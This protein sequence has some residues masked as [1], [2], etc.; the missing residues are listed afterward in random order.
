M[1]DCFSRRKILVPC[2]YKAADRER[3]TC[4]AKAWRK[5]AYGKSCNS[6][7]GGQNCG[8]HFLGRQDLCRCGSKLFFKELQI[9]FHLSNKSFFHFQT[10]TRPC[11]IFG[12][13]FSVN[14]KLSRIAW[15]VQPM[16]S[17]TN[18]GLLR[19]FPGRDSAV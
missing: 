11:A 16:H 8:Q 13:F 7:N 4:R 15:H 10:I 12:Q 19:E 2:T 6:T 3:N 1:Q 14:C 5:S 9:I 18:G 17:D